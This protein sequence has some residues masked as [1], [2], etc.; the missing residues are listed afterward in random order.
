MT[1]PR[2]PM[3]RRIGEKL[4][5]VS[6]AVVGLLV[7][8]VILSALP[9]LKSLVI[10]MPSASGA[11]TSNA[12]FTPDQMAQMQA[13]MA[14]AIRTA[15]GDKLPTQASEFL[16]QS[17]L[18]IFPITI[19]NAVV[20]SLIFIMLVL[21]GRDLATILR[22]GYTKLPD[23]GQMLN[24]GLL[25]VVV[26][27]AYHSY[28]GIFYP[29]LWP[30]SLDIYGW[31]FLALGLAPLVGIVILV[32]RNMDTITAAVMHSGGRAIADSGSSL[33][34]SCGQ[35]VAIGTKFCPN[36]GAPMNVATPREVADKKFCPSCGAENPSSGK[37]CRSCGQAM[38]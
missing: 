6:I 29:L 21:F 1:E 7:L 30:D 22:S 35:T 8:R 37:F 12:P 27:L 5:R 15:L 26:P 2:I 31:S 38:D 25:A 19:A 10:W 9:M 17:H 36:C 23:L 28:Q 3:G 24:L 13:A 4:V 16:I 32:S 33:C 18:A 14:E 20:D 34:G 11:A